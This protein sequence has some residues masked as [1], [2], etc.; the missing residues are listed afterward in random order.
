VIRDLSPF[1]IVI[2]A[3]C[4]LAQT[5]CSAAPPSGTPKAVTATVVDIAPRVSRWN[6]NQVRVTIRSEDGIV[7][8]RI[9][10]IDRLKCRV[11]DRVPAT[12][13]GTVL[14]LDPKACII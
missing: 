7:S 12:V 4:V 1:H 2:A 14:A 8:D 11:G 9:I 6:A 3:M 5:A 13:R 10:T